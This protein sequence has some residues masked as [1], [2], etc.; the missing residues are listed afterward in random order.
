MITRVR[1]T[2]DLLDLKLYNFMIETIKHHLALHNFNQIETPILEPTE[3]FVRSVGSDTDIVSKEMYVFQTGSGESICLRPEGTAGI[4]RAYVENGLTQ[5][6]CWK[7]YIIGPMFRH[8]RPQKGRWR[9]FSQ[10]S[11]ELI[12]ASAIEHDVL[13]LKM[14]DALF[15]EKFKLENY[16]LKLNFLG[17]LDDRRAHRNALLAFLEQN[18]DKICATCTTRKDKN[19]LRVFDCKNEDCQALYKQA[20]LITEHLCTPCGSAWKQ[21]Q[22][23]LGILSVSFQHDPML[24]RGLDYYNKTVFEF[25]SRDLG[26]QNAFCGG[27][28]YS[29]GKEVGG[30]DDFSSFG[31]GIGIGRLL[32]LIEQNQQKLA[33]TQPPALHVIIP[34]TEAQ[35]PLALLLADQL[36][37]HNFATEVI[38][39]TSSVS[40]MMKKANK[41]GAKF[42]LLIG[43][44]EQEQGTVTVKNMLKGET[45]TVKQ[46]DVVSVL[47]L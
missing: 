13:F 17:C 18:S 23:L 38:V 29:L 36:L 6:A 44:D 2:E 11:I 43:Q 28:R 41:L 46:A 37:A 14:L 9:Q 32:M 34:F 19:T 27:G 15:S 12:N 8:E 20:P 7:V 47:R 4:M 39:E 42:A 30:K 31:V 5:Q 24:V 25:S 35:K 21:L 40:N 3:L 1:G 45:S 22:D 33:I 26:A 16:V 10:V